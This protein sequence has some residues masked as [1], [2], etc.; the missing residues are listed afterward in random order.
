MA[1]LPNTITVEAQLRP[2]RFYNSGTFD[3]G[4]FH[5]WVVVSSDRNHPE[6]MVVRGIVEC[7]DGSIN[8]VIADFI[9]FTDGLA[10]TILE[11]TD[12]MN[13]ADDTPENK[14]F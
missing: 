2:C 13:I 10:K 12:T 3:V 4:V 14:I 11:D 9:H 8:L 7:D 5:Q 1:K 6:R